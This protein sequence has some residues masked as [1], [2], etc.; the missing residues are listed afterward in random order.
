MHRTVEISEIKPR[1]E[2]LEAEMP[3]VSREN[4][5]NTPRDVA[6]YKKTSNITV[7]MFRERS[8]FKHRT[9]PD[10]AHR[11]APIWKLTKTAKVKRVVG[12]K[13]HHLQHTISNSFTK[14]SSV[15]R[16]VK[17]RL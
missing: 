5:S 14:C 3:V 17:L 1:I 10:F 13:V 2:S 7:F 15:P 16:S 8:T 4:S 11:A 9:R 6:K 12:K